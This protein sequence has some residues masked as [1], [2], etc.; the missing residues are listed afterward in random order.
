MPHMRPE[1]CRHQ[2]CYATKRPRRNPPARRRDVETGSALTSYKTNGCPPN[3]LSLLGKEYF[4][5]AQLTK[6]AIHAWTWSKVR[7]C[8]CGSAWSGW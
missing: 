6:A 5:A 8:A 4:I 2:R 1:A 3:G 7:V